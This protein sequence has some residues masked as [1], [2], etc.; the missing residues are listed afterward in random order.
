MLWIP[1]DW[2]AQI[3]IIIDIYFW[4]SPNILLEFL[5]L[6]KALANFLDLKF[7]CP[8]P[9]RRP[10]LNLHTLI[11]FQTSPKLILGSI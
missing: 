7:S 11:H 9:H 3:Y 2:L 8:Q 5:Q 4:K 10:F 6:M 1:H